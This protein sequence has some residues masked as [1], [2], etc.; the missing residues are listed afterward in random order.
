MLSLLIAKTSRKKH[1]SVNCK[2]FEKVEVDYHYFNF[3]NRY[4]TSDKT[5]L[6]H[7]RI[8]YLITTENPCQVQDKSTFA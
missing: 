7:F 3:W 4:D 1:L 8:Q 2:I 5:T 6:Y